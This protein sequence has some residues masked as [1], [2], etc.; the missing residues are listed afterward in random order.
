MNS[1]YEPEDRRQNDDYHLKPWPRDHTRG[2][3]TI[4][5][6]RHAGLERDSN[7]EPYHREPSEN[8]HNIYIY[9]PGTLW[10]KSHGVGTV[11]KPVIRTD[12]VVTATMC[13][14][15]AVIRQA[16]RP[17]TAVRA[18]LIRPPAMIGLPTTK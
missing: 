15:T 18:N 4:W 10:T 5:H 9:I 12:N 3:N 16:T 2:T 7:H 8:N 13:S 14:V 1:R 11:T 6:E 17:N